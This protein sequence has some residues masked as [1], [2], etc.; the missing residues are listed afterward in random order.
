MLLEDDCDDNDASSTVVAEDADC[1]GVLTVD[2]CDDND[3]NNTDVNTYDAEC[4]GFYLHSNGITV[5]C[6]DVSVGDTGAVNG[7]S[8]TKELELD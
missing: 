6:P 1:D 5:M 7:V 2:D 4:D 3:A 8:Y